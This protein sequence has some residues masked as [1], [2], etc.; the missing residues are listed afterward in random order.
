MLPDFTSIGGNYDLRSQAAYQITPH[1]FAG[2]YLQ[3]NNTR[4]YNYASIGFYVRYI[5]REQPSTVTAPTGL[6][7][8]DGL[9][10]FNVP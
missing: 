1:L 3:A 7:P 8:A 9:R 2:G 10:P 4:N 5:F 6:F